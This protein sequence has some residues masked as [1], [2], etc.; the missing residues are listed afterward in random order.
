MTSRQHLLVAG[1]EDD[2]RPARQHRVRDAERLR[3][4]HLAAGR[5]LRVAGGAARPREGD[6]PT[7]RRGRARQR[8]RALARS[9]LRDDRHRRDRREE[10]D[11]GEH[12]QTLGESRRHATKCG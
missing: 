7:G 3:G 2:L 5:P 1:A 4:E 10:R 6:V 11:G 12:G 9:A 8:S